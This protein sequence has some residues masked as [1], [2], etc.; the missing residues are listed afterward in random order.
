[1]NDIKYSDWYDDS[2]Q[3]MVFILVDDFDKNIDIFMSFLTTAPDKYLK[4]LL[5]P[6]SHLLLYLPKD[7]MRTTALDEYISNTVIFIIIN[8]MQCDLFDL[9]TIHV[10]IQIFQSGF[11]QPLFL[12]YINNVGFVVVAII[13]LDLTPHSLN[14]PLDAC[15]AHGPFL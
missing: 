9:V 1:M 15:D 5:F 7:N 4:W 8:Q 11:Q 3:I 13:N 12:L 6:W 14:V 2:L 10:F